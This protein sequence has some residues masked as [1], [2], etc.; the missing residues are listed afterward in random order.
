MQNFM[1]HFNKTEQALSCEFQLIS[2]SV[3]M[4]E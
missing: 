2:R 3:W 4:G 1:V